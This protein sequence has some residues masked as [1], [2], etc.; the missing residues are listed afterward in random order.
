MRLVLELLAARSSKRLGQLVLVQVSCLGE[1][2]GYQSHKLH[3]AL[4]LGQ[5]SVLLFIFF[6]V[7]FF[8]FLLTEYSRHKL[9]WAPVLGQG[10]QLK[11]QIFFS[12]VFVRLMAN[13]RKITYGQNCRLGKQKKESW[14]FCSLY[15]EFE[16]KSFGSAETIMTPKSKKMRL[17]CCP[18]RASKIQDVS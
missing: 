5:A 1:R 9:Y 6:L 4:V 13:G 17:K 10:W 8:L 11:V 16:L 12:L 14:V 18:L 7:L 3:P 2:S 15:Y